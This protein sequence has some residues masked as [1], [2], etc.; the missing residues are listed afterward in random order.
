MAKRAVVLVG[1]WAAYLAL[2]LVG[3]AT[4]GPAVDFSRLPPEEQSRTLPA[5]AIVAAI[6]LAVIGFLVG[7]ARHRGRRLWLEVGLVFYGVKTLS[8]TLE[9]MFFVREEHVPRRMIPGLLA[10]T[11]PLAVAWTG[12]VVR[13]LA[14]RGPPEPPVPV[15]RSP[16]S[17]AWRIALAGMLIYPVLFFGFGYF[18]AWQNEAVRV[19]YT[20]SAQLLGLLPHLAQV[21][22]DQ[23][24]VIP[25]EMFRGLLWVAMAWVIVRGV[26]GPPWVVALL[27]ASVFALVHNDVQLLPN[28][29]MPAEVRYWHLLETASSN[30]L[31]G[32]VTAALL[33]PRAARTRA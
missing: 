1:L 20:G 22:R 21:F 8:S 3:A 26:S 32:A 13:S 23:P 14:R 11:L 28:P 12:L 5:L 30:F 2:F 17:L 10:M 6:D 18:V 29:L 24:A 27:V 15:G 9:V 25:F 31:F 33:S 4:L 16:A 7:R 19:Y